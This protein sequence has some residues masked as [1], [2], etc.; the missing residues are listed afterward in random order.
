MEDCRAGAL[1]PAPPNLS[2]RPSDRLLPRRANARSTKTEPARYQRQ[3]LALIDIIFQIRKCWTSAVCSL[4]LPYEVQ[5]E[6]LNKIRK[7]VR[8]SRT[9]RPEAG[10]VHATSQTK[11]KGQVSD[12]DLAP[13]TH[14][15]NKCLHWERRHRSEEK[16]TVKTFWYWSKF[17]FGVIL[18]VSA[19]GFNNVHS[20]SVMIS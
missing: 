6:L 9:S 8:D 4:T 18:L 17:L 16:A 20:H 5:T 12:L 3:Q 2:D 15:R 10:G 11:E 13:S 1:A 7:I 14:G 19:I